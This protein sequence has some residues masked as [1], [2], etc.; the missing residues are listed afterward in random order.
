MLTNS[1][2]MLLQWLN[3]IYLTLGGYYGDGSH[4]KWEQICSSLILKGSVIPWLV[5]F[6]R[7]EPFPAALRSLQSESA[8]STPLAAPRAPPTALLHSSFLVPDGAASLGHIT[9]CFQPVCSHELR[10]LC[11]LGRRT[12]FELR[13][14]W[15]SQKLGPI[16][17]GAINSP[18]FISLKDLL[19]FLT[20]AISTLYK[21]SKAWGLIKQLY[22]CNLIEGPFI[23]PWRSSEN[24]VWTS[25]KIH[26]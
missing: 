19:L 25:L 20:S 26:K 18:P 2:Q 14:T 10:A 15:L 3:P 7:E 23:Y 11:C 17:F 4:Y 6:V 9:H 5:F 1:W 12:F 24:S 8:V 16:I 22:L 13:I 21:W